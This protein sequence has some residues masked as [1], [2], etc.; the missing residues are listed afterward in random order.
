MTARMP[1]NMKAAWPLATPPDPYAGDLTSSFTLDGDTT[2]ARDASGSPP[3]AQMLT[4]LARDLTLRVEGYRGPDELQVEVWCY[5]R[6]EDRPSEWSFAPSLWSLFTHKLVFT[7]KAWTAP[8]EWA[9]RLEAEDSYFEAWDRYA[10]AHASFRA[11]YSAVKAVFDDERAGLIGTDKLRYEG[12]DLSATADTEVDEVDDYAELVTTDLEAIDTRGKRPADEHDACD[13]A[14][15]YYAESGAAFDEDDDEAPVE[16]EEEDEAT[17]LASSA[18]DEAAYDAAYE[19]YSRLAPPADAAYAAYVAAYDSHLDGRFT[20]Y[21][22]GHSQAHAAAYA[23]ARA[24]AYAAAYDAAYYFAFM[25]RADADQA[26]AVAADCAEWAANDKKGRA[27]SAVA[28]Y[29]HREAARQGEKGRG[30]A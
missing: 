15:D 11:A 7:G 8:R 21:A 23:A 14:D 16:D 28:D 22:V 3:G 27:A 13:D 26:G 6:V 9:V 18:A 19:A 29:T 24:A 17:A 2:F 4:K 25:E 10:A 1:H 5:P 30:H 12:G 20:D